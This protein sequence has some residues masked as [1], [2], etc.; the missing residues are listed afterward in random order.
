[1]RDFIEA[2]STEKSA[3]A[4]NPW[5][6]A[7]FEDRAFALIAGKQLSLHGFSAYDHGADLA[8]EKFHSILAGARR[9][10]EDRSGGI[11]FDEDRD[12]RKQRSG[13][14]EGEGREQQIHPAL[15]ETPEGVM[16]SLGTT[17]CN[18]VQLG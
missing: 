6:I 15:E 13:Q 4:G 1:L 18:H 9:P 8:A 11:Q 2:E 14:K 17:W 10:I 3:Y 12:Y 16:V 7:E 5:V